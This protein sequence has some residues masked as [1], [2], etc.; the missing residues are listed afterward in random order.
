M[1][2]SGIVFTGRLKGFLFGPDWHLKQEVE[3]NNLV[4][5]VGLQHI[6]DQIYSVPA[7]G[8]MSHYAIGTGVTAPVA[9]DTTLQTEIARVALDNQIRSGVDLIY[10]A[11]FLPGIGTGTLTEGG[12][13]NAGSNGVM[14]ARTTFTAVVKAAADTF[15]VTHKITATGS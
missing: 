13:F 14:L 3:S 8:K 6:V 4:V 5:T 10:S 1:N 9:G 7:Q 2:L 12:I 11:V 15:I